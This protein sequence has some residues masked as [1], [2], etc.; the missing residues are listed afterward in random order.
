M[1][2]EIL[3]SSLSQHLSFETARPFLSL[4]PALIFAPPRTCL[5]RKTMLLH[6]LS[7]LLR[8]Y[9][10]RAA[11]ISKCTGRHKCWPVGHHVCILGDSLVAE[12]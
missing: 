12:D 4:R 8:L 1:F 6:R 3:L 7:P 5:P 2:A 10:A 9:P 11:R